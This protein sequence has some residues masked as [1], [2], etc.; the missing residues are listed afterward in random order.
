G[1]YIITLAVLNGL[2]LVL[3]L[4]DL[5]P[6]NGLIFVVAAYSLICLF[7][8]KYFWNRDLKEELNRRLHL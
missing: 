5:H 6:S 4:F 3:G 2:L 7:A 8:I 1:V